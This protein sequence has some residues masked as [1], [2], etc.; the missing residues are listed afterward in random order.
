[1]G[2]VTMEVVLRLQSRC[3]GRYGE[4]NL[5][6]CATHTHCA[7]GGLSRHGLYSL[8]PPLKGF[9]GHHFEHVVS[10]IVEAVV[11]AENQMV[12]AVL[13]VA[14]GDIDGASVNRSPA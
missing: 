6:I 7:P 12:P 1:M 2:A 3:A 4:A 14:Q 9:D 10:G 5:L 11:E 8:H 13:Q